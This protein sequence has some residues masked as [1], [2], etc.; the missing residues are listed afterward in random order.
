MQVGDYPV[1]NCPPVDERTDRRLPSTDIVGPS[2]QGS[3]ISASEVE[4]P[5]T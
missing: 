1:D 4:E 3:Y 5:Y 2:C